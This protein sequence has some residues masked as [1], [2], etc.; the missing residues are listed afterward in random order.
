VTNPSGSD[1]LSSDNAEC[2]QLQ[3]LG[4]VVAGA[5]GPAACKHL[6]GN[7]NSTNGSTL[8]QLM[9]I[10]FTPNHGHVY[11]AWLVPVSCVTID[12]INLKV[13]TFDRSCAKT[14]NFKVKDTGGDPLQGLSTIT[15]VKFYD[16][17]TN[18]LQDG[19]EFGI[20]GW[21]IERTFASEL[22]DFV[23]TVGPDGVYTF[24]I[25]VPD[26]K[27][28]HTISEAPPPPGWFPAWQW[29]NTTLTS[30]DVDVTGSGTYP[31]P[32]FGNVSVGAG[33]N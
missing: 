31:G 17:N 10:N 19:G 13:I 29:I 5:Y 23:F 3:V 14:D 26:E 16:A 11:E 4:G 32:N 30:G 18:G 25:Q 12:S 33:A 7:Y 20:V 6:D 1:L 2:R 9:P 27:G 28:A 22:A 24:S 15:G 8:V 21:R